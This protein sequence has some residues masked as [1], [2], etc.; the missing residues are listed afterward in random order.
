VACLEGCNPFDLDEV[1]VMDGVK[2][3][4]DTGEARVLGVMKFIRG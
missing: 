1:P 2:H 4:S 3:P